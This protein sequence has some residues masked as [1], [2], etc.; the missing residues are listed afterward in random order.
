MCVPPQFVWSR[1]GTEA[2]QEISDILRRKEGER[3]ANSG[4]FY[5]GI[6]NALGPSI[7]ELLR[8][9][10]SPEV[11]FSPIRSTPKKEDVMPG[12][13]VAW[14]EAKG[15]DGTP[16]KIPDATLVTSRYTEGRAQHY[17][18]VCMSEAAII[19]S[20]AQGTVSLQS[21][22]NILSGRP[23]GASQVT[24]VVS[25]D[26]DGQPKG[27]E[28]SVRFKA[29][30]VYPYFVYLRS[31]IFLRKDPFGNWAKLVNKLSAHRLVSW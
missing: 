18:L 2:G 13:I 3:K 12:A 16:H 31:P 5:W 20:D 22:R 6:G 7:T 4:I 23:I 1:F 11:L 21:L 9:C 26:S 15:L 27:T 30:L 29:K 10:E 8:T 28:Y 25:R 17:A 24:A 19:A 14:T